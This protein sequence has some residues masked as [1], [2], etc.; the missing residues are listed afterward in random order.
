MGCGAIA[1]SFHL[2]ALVRSPEVRDHLV[3]VDPDLERAGALARKHGV[4]RVV[5]ELGDVLGAIDGAIVAVPPRL[6]HEVALACLERGHPVLCEKPLCSDPGAARELVETA[7]R[8]G[9]RLAVNQTRRLFPAFQ[10]VRERIAGGE[11]GRIEE[12]DYVLGEPFDWPAAT[13]S[14]FGLRGGG[15]GVLLDI[16]AH[17][18]DLV[19]WW[20]G[21]RPRVVDYRDD[22]FGGTEAVAG[23]T[24][25]HEGCRVHMRLSWLSKLENR[26]RIRGE[27]AHL[28]GGV[29]DWGSY[30]L[31]A[32]PES[33]R[34][35]TTRRRMRGFDDAA[36]GLIDNFLEVVTGRAEPLVPG[37]E[38]LPS[39]GI[40]DECYAGR[41]RFDLP[42]HDAWDRIDHA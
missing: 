8:I 18:V 3:L 15:R 39:I 4:R 21:G 34:K 9:T 24:L 40:I 12:I 23:V 20:L 10:E 41:A 37:R 22:S 16:G 33:L 27:R 7:D 1:D 35:T 32:T 36:N 5:P 28:E 6:H 25:E 11:L 13:D 14:Y 30:D 26:Y 42:W 17:I 2:P 29:Y 19:C 38:V 31:G